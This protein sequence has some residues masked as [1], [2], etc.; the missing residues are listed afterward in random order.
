LTVSILQSENSASGSGL[1]GL[2][3]SVTI[4]NTKVFYYILRQ[5]VDI[6]GPYVS[7][8]FINNN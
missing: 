4:K 2:I 1:G 6:G 7:P 5:E 3:Q 8:R